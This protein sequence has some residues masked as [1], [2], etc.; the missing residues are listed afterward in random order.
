[1]YEM[2]QKPAKD[3]EHCEGRWRSLPSHDNKHS[4]GLLPDPESEPEQQNTQLTGFVA[5]LSTTRHFQYLVQTK[6]S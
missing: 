6:L 5:H 1:M 3:Q 4:S 2:T